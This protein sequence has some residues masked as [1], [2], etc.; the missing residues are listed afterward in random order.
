MGSPAALTARIQLTGIAN[1][2][3]A[4]AMKE[5]NGRSD[6]EAAERA[7]AAG[8]ARAEPESSSATLSLTVAAQIPVPIDPN[9]RAARAN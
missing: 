9:R 3:E 4:S 8:S 6:D 5:A 2:C 7:V 1:L